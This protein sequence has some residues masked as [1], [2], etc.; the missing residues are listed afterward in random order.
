VRT[1]SFYHEDTG[2]L[3]GTVA[4]CS[5][6][7]VLKANTPADHMAIEGAH[8]GSRLKVDIETKELIDYQPPRPSPDHDWN[9][10]TK[11][12]ELNAAVAAKKAAAAA[13]RS[14]I[15]SL[16]TSQHQDVRKHILGDVTALARLQAIDAEISQL[17][18]DL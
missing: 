18:K 6:A 5:D 12:W 13:A 17:E 2:V 10:T 16:V 3:N 11:R 15:S 4:L 9:G 14:K 8:D 7:K 1:F